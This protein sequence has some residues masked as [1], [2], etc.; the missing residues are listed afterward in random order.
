MGE[1]DRT[2]TGPS[3]HRDAPSA[4]GVLLGL[5]ERYSAPLLAGATRVVL[6]PGEVLFDKGDVGDGC[7]WVK[8]G[9]LKVKVA[10]PDGDERILALL[11]RG[12]VVGELAMLD[13][14]PRSATVQAIRASELSFISRSAFQ[15]V[16]ETDRG[17]VLQLLSTLAQRLRKSDEDAT[18]AS[19]LSVRVRVAR[20]LL[21]MTLL[22]GDG[23]ARDG[24][25]LVPHDL[26]QADIG[27]LAGVSRESVSRVMA[28]LRKDGILR[29]SGRFAHR[30][31]LAR[32]E[33]EVS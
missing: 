16:L 12:A 4:L 11:G 3:T 21:H 6:R 17:L 1:L 5:P 31:D 13:G 33:R 25:V 7:Y 10:S 15:T 20:A 9:I 24:M 23:E 22:F 14:Q 26:R 30:I 32:L 2:A 19:F 8:G 18:A 27:A 29:K 28:T